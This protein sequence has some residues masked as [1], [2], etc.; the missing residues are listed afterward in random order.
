MG[1][2]VVLS[3]EQVQEILENKEKLTNKELVR[4]YEVSIGTILNVKAGRSVYGK[5]TPEG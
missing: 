3:P 1:R 2:R 5:A 4:K